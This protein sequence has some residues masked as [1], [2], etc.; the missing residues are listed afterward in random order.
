MVKKSAAAAA[1][2]DA[3]AAHKV[4]GA[5]LEGKAEGEPITKEELRAACER[6]L[7]SEDSALRAITGLMWCPSGSARR[8]LVPCSAAERAEE[9]RAAAG[10]A[11]SLGIIGPGNVCLLLVG[12][13]P[14]P[15]HSDVCALL[16]AVGAGVLPCSARSSEDYC[17][18]TAERFGANTVVGTPSRLLRLAWHLRAEAR[19]LELRDVLLVGE[20]PTPQQLQWISEAFGSETH[21]KFFPPRI[22]SAWGSSETGIVGFSPPGLHDPLLVLYDDEVWHF[23][24]APPPAGSIPRIA[25]ERWAEV[26]ENERKLGV[27][28]WRSTT[29]AGKAPSKGDPVHWTTEMLEPLR[30]EDVKLPA[31]EEGEWHFEGEWKAG[32][33][34]YGYDWSEVGTPE[35]LPLG[36]LPQRGGSKPQLRRRRWRIKL[37]RTRAPEEAPGAGLLVATALTRKRMPLARYSLGDCGAL[38]EAK[39]GG[40]NWRAFRQCGLRHEIFHLLGHVPVWVTEFEPHL[41]EY[42]DWQIEHTIRDDEQG[43]LDCL[44]IRI[45]TQPAPSTGSPGRPGA[46]DLGAE[47]RKTLGM[48]IRETLSRNRPK[49]AAL[50]EFHLDIQV[51]EPAQLVCDELSG[52]LR[53]LVDLSTQVAASPG[54]SPLRDDAS[55]VAPGSSPSPRRPARSPGPSDTVSMVSF[56]PDGK[57][58]SQSIAPSRAGSDSDT[59]S[60]FPGGGGGGFVA[61]PGRA[62]EGFHLSASRGGS[63]A[64]SG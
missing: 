13:G 50:P 15:L 6:G 7:N 17:V 26:W 35:W 61:A 28:G 16:R 58:Y 29:V 33:W 62:H 45:A 21:G 3:A 12:G 40:R 8:P 53:R 10:L 2:A 18:R 52:R 42:A 24:T 34:I 41:N 57:S 20:V 47:R 46:Q 11:D 44:R 39:S 51:C 1:A 56:S 54:R 31:A 49:G 23:A 27:A 43:C 64:S 38:R 60:V 59:A 63:L 55:S 14:H 4:Y 5:L 9:L 36:E 25:S 37:V 19:R 32:E 22:A 30:K 48:A